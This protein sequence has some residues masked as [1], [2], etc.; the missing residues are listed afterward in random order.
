MHATCYM[1]LVYQG[2]I[3][4]VLCMSRHGCAV[5]AG[6]QHCLGCWPFWKEGITLLRMPV[7]LS[8]SAGAA[9]ATTY[10]TIKCCLF[11]S[12][13]AVKRACLVLR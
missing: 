12:C 6:Q 3:P 1:Q 9:S 11:L 8:C 10:T 5:T 7:F 13:P 2:G 4:L